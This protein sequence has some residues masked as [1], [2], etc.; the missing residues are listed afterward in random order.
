M[1]DTYNLLVKLTSTLNK[2]DDIIKLISSHTKNSFACNEEIINVG[3][4]LVSE[5]SNY[6]SF[7]DDEV[8]MLS[9]KLHELSD[10]IRKYANNL[11]NSYKFVN[12]YKLYDCITIDI[13]NL[14]TYLNTLK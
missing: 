1:R 11:F 2:C 9:N 13:N 7:L 6:L 3:I 4:G 12:A 5:V 14:K 10:P 8:Y